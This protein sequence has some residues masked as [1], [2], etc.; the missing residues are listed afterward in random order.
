MDFFKPE[1]DKK[2][3]ESR[4]NDLY[5]YVQDG[6]MTLDFAAKKSNQSVEDFIADMEKH[7]YKVPQMV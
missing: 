7:G 6:G 5:E 2:I 1:I 3:Y 4:Q